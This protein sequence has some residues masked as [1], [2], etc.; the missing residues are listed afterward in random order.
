MGLLESLINVPE[1]LRIWHLSGVRYLLQP[2]TSP[3]ASPAEPMQPARPAVPAPWPQGWLDI[4]AKTPR[5]P[6]LVITYAQLG[7]DLTGRADAR[8]GALW[9]RLISD[10]GLA[11]RNLVAF[12][13]LTLPEGEAMVT[14]QDV[15]LAGLARLAPDL[16]AFFGDATATAFPLDPPGPTGKAVAGIPCAVLPDPETLLNGDTEVWDHVLAQLGDI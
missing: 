1:P 14:R 13:P 2:E 8:R 12:W 6:R 7:L 9:R 5:K 11:G 10:L 16:V 3:E 15:Y 4:L